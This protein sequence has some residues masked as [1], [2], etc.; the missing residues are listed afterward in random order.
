M[1]K[2]LN[3]YL[4]S[5][6]THRQQAKYW[7]P[8][9]YIGVYIVVTVALLPAS[10]LTVLAGI[11]FG[12]SVCILNKQ[13][14]SLT[15]KNSIYL[16]LFLENR[17]ICFFF[18]FF[19]IG[20]FLDKIKQIFEGFLVVSAGSVLGATAAFLLGR[21]ALRNWVKKKIAVRNFILLY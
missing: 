9:A 5:N 21:F 6:E 2:I 1:W 11:I 8:A 4:K 10:L 19:I 18:L 15:S 20:I 16:F 17:N 3:F 7:A 14:S 12:V 13:P